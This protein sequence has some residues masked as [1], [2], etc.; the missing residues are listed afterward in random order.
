MAD[1]CSS[2]HTDVLAEEGMLQELLKEALDYKG[3][4]L[5][6]RYE[7]LLRKKYPEEI[8]NKYAA[9]VCAEADHVSDRKQYRK[10]MKEL[11]KLTR[12]IGGR[13]LAQ[14]IAVKWRDKYSR[15]PAFIDELQKT[16][17]LK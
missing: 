14:E 1:T 7:K 10:L 5:I 16:G 13:E 11:K 15:R 8:R 3:I 4:Y 6:E 12:Y 17:F 2:I 9:Y